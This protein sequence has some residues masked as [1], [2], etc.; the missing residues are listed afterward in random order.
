[1]LSWAH[2]PVSPS[3]CPIPP[4]PPPLLLMGHRPPIKSEGGGGKE[5]GLLQECGAIQ[6]KKSRLSTKI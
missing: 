5:E 1:M 4:P 2:K 3:S 6:E